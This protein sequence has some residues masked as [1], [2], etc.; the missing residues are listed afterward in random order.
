ML[1]LDGTESLT[2]QGVSCLP[3]RTNWQKP[4]KEEEGLVGDF[5]GGKL[6]RGTTVKHNSA[7]AS[8]ATFDYL[9]NANGRKS[10]KRPAESAPWEP[11]TRDVTEKGVDRSK[12]RFPKARRHRLARGGVSGKHVNRAK[13]VE[14]ILSAHQ[15]AEE[16]AIRQAAMRRK[17]TF[18]KQRRRKVCRAREA[19]RDTQA[20]VEVKNAERKW[21]DGQPADAEEKEERAKSGQQEQLR[22]SVGGCRD[23]KRTTSEKQAGG[24]FSLERCKVFFKKT[25]PQKINHAGAPAAPIVPRGQ[26]LR[27]GAMCGRSGYRADISDPE[28]EAPTNFGVGVREAFVSAAA[29]ADADS[30]REVPRQPHT[31]AICGAAVRAASLSRAGPSA[32]PSP[33]DAAH[34]DT[35]CRLSSVQTTPAADGETAGQTRDCREV[36]RL[37][38]GGPKRKSN[39]SE[40]EWETDSDSEE[41]DEIWKD[42]EELNGESDDEEREDEAEGGS[43]N[44]AE[45]E[46]GPPEETSDDGGEKSSEDASKSNEGSEENMEVEL[47]RPMARGSNQGEGNN[48]DAE[49]DPSLSGGAAA[50]PLVAR[51]GTIQSLPATPNERATQDALQVP[52]EP[53]RRQPARKRVIRTMDLSDDEMSEGAGKDESEERPPNRRQRM[54]DKG[55]LGRRFGSGRGYPQSAQDEGG[56][57]S[58]QTGLEDCWKKLTANETAARGGNEQEVGRLPREVGRDSLVQRTTGRED[59]ARAIYLQNTLNVRIEEKTMKRD[60]RISHLERTSVNEIDEIETVC[61]LLRSTK[62]VKNARQ[63]LREGDKKSFMQSLAVAA[64][65][66]GDARLCN[67]GVKL[68]TKNS[69]EFATDICKLFNTDINSKARYFTLPS[70]AVLERIFQEDP[71]L[72]FSFCLSGFLQG[73]GCLMKCRPSMIAK[74]PAILFVSGSL[75]A[76]LGI[77]CSIA[78]CF[79]VETGS[80]SICVAKIEEDDVFPEDDDVHVSKKEAEPDIDETE[81]QPERKGRV[82][83]SELSDR[84]ERQGVRLLLQVARA[85]SKEIKDALKRWAQEIGAE[86]ENSDEEDSEGG[87]VVWSKELARGLACR[88]AKRFAYDRPLTYDLVMRVVIEEL[89]KIYLQDAGDGRKVMY[90]LTYTAKHDVLKLAVILV[91]GSDWKTAVT[92]KLEAFVKWATT[93]KEI[94]KGNF[95]GAQKGIEFREGIRPF[96]QKSNDINPGDPHCCSSLE[97]Q[98]YHLKRWKENKLT[99]DQYRTASWVSSKSSASGRLKKENINSTVETD[100]VYWEQRSNLWDPE[101]NKRIHQHEKRFEVPNGATFDPEVLR[102]KFLQRP[103]QLGLFLRGSAEI[104]SDLPVTTSQ[105]KDGECAFLVE[106]AWLKDL[107]DWLFKQPPC[108][109][110]PSPTTYEIKTTWPLLLG[111]EHSTA[112]VVTS[113]QLFVL[114]TLLRFEDYD[115]QKLPRVPVSTGAGRKR[116]TVADLRPASIKE[117]RLRTAGGLLTTT[118]SK[119]W[120]ST[121]WTME[122]LRA[123]TKEWCYKGLKVDQTDYFGTLDWRTEVTLLVDCAPVGQARSVAFNSGQ[124]LGVFIEKGLESALERAERPHCRDWTR[125]E[126]IVVGEEAAPPGVPKA[127]RAAVEKSRMGAELS[128]GASEGGDGDQRAGGKRWEPYAEFNRRF[129]GTWKQQLERARRLNLS[130]MDVRPEQ[131]NALEARIR[132]KLET[133]RESL[134]DDEKEID[135]EI[136]AY[137]L[138]LIRTVEMTL[139]W[140]DVSPR[141]RNWVYDQHLLNHIEMGGWLCN[142]CDRVVPGEDSDDVPRNIRCCCT[143]GERLPKG[144]GRSQPRTS[145]EPDH[146]CGSRKIKW[147]TAACG[148][149]SIL[150][151]QKTLVELG[152]ATWA[153]AGPKK[154]RGTRVPYTWPGPEGNGAEGSITTIQMAK[155]MW[156]VLLNAGF[157]EYVRSMNLLR[158]LGKRQQKIGRETSSRRGNVTGGVATGRNIEEDSKNSKGR[159]RRRRTKGEDTWKMLGHNGLLGRG[160]GAGCWLEKQR[161]RVGIC[162]PLS[163]PQVVS[164]L[165]AGILTRANTKPTGNRSL[166]SMD[167]EAFETESSKVEPSTPHLAQLVP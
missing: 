63:V 98:Q 10:A 56:R 157:D 53:S 44:E 8:R 131:V 33:S 94:G 95:P 86:D 43:M 80:F 126:L 123:K 87:G 108:G 150:V 107:T 66:V 153:L 64:F 88:A 30:V 81:T 134:G 28:A 97:A 79:G 39:Y 55:E 101:L 135:I 118:Q 155:L 68:G 161:E 4:E 109:P 147:S 26:D 117:V 130:E 154:F 57:P 54:E 158:S 129:V 31:A 27:A 74:Y 14:Q 145:P 121:N 162:K 48:A 37:R 142:K 132:Q 32:T 69:K 45:A 25:G 70:P 61:N 73:E 15:R 90:R 82:R 106:E 76:I 138:T 24:F 20:G 159:R 12:R 137:G 141:A 151:V 93:F 67:E 40:E 71:G 49:E 115:P 47:P 110:P 78:R 51:I 139:T 144:R 7:V 119:L 5:K 3:L 116:G 99:W 58:Q 83:Y 133:I 16:E 103:Q 164:A 122:Q 34:S 102:N 41:S 92:T 9:P 36:L 105:S 11:G 124:T 50:A 23:E 13:A 100:A 17:A 156:Q 85:R 127:L 166:D 72:L 148:G 35:P 125:V 42:L 22:H 146:K 46:T 96:A 114:A 38:G 104:C 2:G 149:R 84:E 165:S 60:V 160:V 6:V 59:G 29:P 1:C 91:I 21:Q 62:L 167:E 75:K 140:A 89:E 19:E 120:V 65:A 18:E 143:E 52:T 113:Y 128:E 163:G 152:C 77:W 112:M 136:K 111:T